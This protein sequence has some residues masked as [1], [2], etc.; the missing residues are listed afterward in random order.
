MSEAIGRK[1]IVGDRVC[2]K[3][4]KRLCNG[5]DYIFATVVRLTN[6]RAIL[7]NKVSLIN[8]PELCGWTD[9]YIGYKIYGDT[10]SNYQFE[11]PELIEEHRADQAKI[12][13]D[14]WCYD[15]QK[16]KLTDE[17]KTLLYNTFNK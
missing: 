14:N 10:L 17:E 9:K 8:I 16:R 7:S 2:K 13:L 1:L 11:T 12:K 6:T 4:G 3:Q 5:Y 15:F